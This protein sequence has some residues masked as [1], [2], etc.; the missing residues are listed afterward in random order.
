[1]S[2]FSC[3]GVLIKCIAQD[4]SPLYSLYHPIEGLGDPSILEGLMQIS[5]ESKLREA[6][7]GLARNAGVR[8]SK[9]PKVQCYTSILDCSEES[10]PVSGGRNLKIKVQNICETREALEKFPD[11]KFI[12]DFNGRGRAHEITTFFSR[13]SSFLEHVLYLEDPVPQ[14]DLPELLSKVSLP[15]ARDMVKYSEG[16][17]YEIVKPTGFAVSKDQHCELPLVYTSYLDH[18]LGQVLAAIECA[19]NP[20][21]T[22]EQLHGL[23]THH[24]F[25]AN[26]YSEILGS[27]DSID[28]SAINE[29]EMLLEKESW[30]RL[31]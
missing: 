29:M 25:E 9:L 10:T 14:G 4:S 21:R 22:Q 26:P 31:V 5:T 16:F 27:D 3:E 28:P 23:A 18:P 8:G 13:S 17:Q 20:K 6:V 7:L 19:E 2:H 12:F 24:F 15:V 1:M 11:C 30:K